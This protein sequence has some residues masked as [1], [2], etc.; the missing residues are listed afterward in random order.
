MLYVI[1]FFVPPA[2]LLLSRKPLLAI[3]AFACYVLT[4][5]GAG[6]L[7]VPGFILYF[8]PFLL[9]WFGIFWFLPATV[10]VAT[11]KARNTNKRAPERADFIFALRALSLTL[12][13]IVA[14]PVTG[15]ALFWFYA[16]HR[17][18]EQLDLWRATP[19]YTVRWN[20]AAIEGFP[21]VARLRLTDAIFGGVEPSPYELSAPVMVIETAP[22]IGY[23][24]RVWTPV[25]ARLDVPNFAVAIDAGVIDIGANW[26]S[27]S[28]PGLITF[29][30]RGLTGAK[31][32]AEL[33]IDNVFGQVQLPRS[34]VDARERSLGL[35]VSV[36]E[37]ALSQPL[38]PLGGNIK[39]AQIILNLKDH[40]PPGPLR[41]AL[42]DWRDRGGS[43]EVLLGTLDWEP[44][45]LSIRDGM[46]KLDQTLQPIGSFIMTATDGVDAIDA[47]K[48]AG[49]LSVPEAEA[50]KSAFAMAQP[51]SDNSARPEQK[52]QI[53]DGSLMLGTTKIL[54]LPRIFWP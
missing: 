32:I 10:A 13:L 41:N 5:I 44:F 34:A 39:R 40:W 11:V 42:V 4:L 31:A 24:L 14:A 12:F 37:V 18:R 52:V 53:E 51:A 49:G 26:Q 6:F 47:I 8:F 21:F 38:P 50:A 20:E 3:A 27:S 17:L 1:A 9:L 2:A 19:G 45:G 7:V 22:W 35:N 36:D 54:A 33:H 15:R 48:T 25:G 29:E 23:D 16:A 28:T 46:L 30:A 43:V